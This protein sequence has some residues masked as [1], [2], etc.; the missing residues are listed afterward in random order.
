LYP[1]V[2]IMETD[3]GDLALTSPDPE[4]VAIEESLLLQTTL[5]VNG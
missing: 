4:T 3:P 5:S 1:R 2:A